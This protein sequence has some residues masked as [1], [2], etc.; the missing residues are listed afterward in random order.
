MELLFQ[1]KNGARKFNLFMEYS[2][3]FS[4]K[5]VSLSL[6][7]LLSPALSLSLSSSSSFLYYSVN[8]NLQTDSSVLPAIAFLFNIKENPKALWTAGLQ[9][10]LMSKC[11]EKQ[12]VLITQ[13]PYFSGWQKKI[14]RCRKNMISKCKGLDRDKEIGFSIV[15]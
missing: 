4:C 3:Y 6:P 10:K 12:P 14:F 2:L 1:L 15:K 9:Q 8:E 11:L 7:L 5:A 13:E